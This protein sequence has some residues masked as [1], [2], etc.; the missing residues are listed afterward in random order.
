MG[1]DIRK[2]FKE[3]SEIEKRKMPFGHQSRFE[4]KLDQGFNHKKSTPLFFLKI[5]ASMVL[6]F[7][8]GYVGFNSF[9]HQDVGG[10]LIKID[11]DNK[12]INSLAD[13]S[14]DLEKVE[15]YYLNHIRYQLSKIQITDAN[16]AYFEI[17]VSQL[18]ELQKVYKIKVSELNSDEISEEVINELIENLQSR[19][20]L[21]YQLKAQLKKIKNLNKQENESNQA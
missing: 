14:P 11:T 2:L 12:K 1:Q 5:A 16:R 10:S 17:Y 8:L 19:L 4:S 9:N 7:S 15:D 21:M 20:K 13:I 3:V 18:S 6:I